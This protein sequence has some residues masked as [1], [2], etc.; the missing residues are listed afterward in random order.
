MLDS[1]LLEFVGER[2]EHEGETDDYTNFQKWSSFVNGK[3]GFLYGIP[4]EHAYQVLKF[5]PVDKSLELMGPD[6]HYRA[7]W[8]GVLA[9][10]GCIYSIPCNQGR[11][12]GRLLKINTIKG[13]VEHLELEVQPHGTIHIFSWTLG[14]VGPDDCIYF[15][16]SGTLNQSVLR[17]DPSTDSAS[18]IEL[19]NPRFTSLQGAVLGK[20]N[21]IYGLPSGGSNEA[22]GV[23]K[24]DPME[25]EKTCFFEAYDNQYDFS[26]NGI[27]ASD[28]N[29]YALNDEGQV[30]K[31]DTSARSTTTIGGSVNRPG[32][33][34]VNGWGDPIIGNDKCIYWPPHYSR[35]VMKFD[36]TTQESPRLVGPP[37]TSIFCCSW[38]GGARGDD[39]VIYCPPFEDNNILAIDPLR[40]LSFRMKTRLRRYPMLLGRLFVQKGW[41]FKESL[42]EGAVRKFGYDTALRILDESIPSTEEWNALPSDNIPLFILTASSGKKGNVGDVPLDII[43]HLM[44]KNVHG[45]ITTLFEAEFN[46][47]AHNTIYQ[48]IL[49][50]TD[51]ERM[52]QPSWHFV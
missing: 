7:W 20:D 30:L 33:Y 34:Y 42:F 17:L 36:P 46:Y 48:S 12:E 35:Q 2:V 25:P 22:H 43:Y 51:L 39:G 19:P 15:L 50:N 32:L 44:R 47:I 26:T 21:C 8:G 28:G 13:T 10:N 9:K 49:I 52:R 38:N 27:L 40:E 6:L 1:P 18:L 24:F 45:L 14:V 3:D 4:D 16:P 11:H 37:D 5:N 29:I 23:M 41:R 31:L